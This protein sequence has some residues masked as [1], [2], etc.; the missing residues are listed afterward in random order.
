MWSD[1]VHTVAGM[2]VLPWLG[3][4]ST[5]GHPLDGQSRENRIHLNQLAYGTVNVFSVLRS[6]AD[7][8]RDGQEFALV[9]IHHRNV[10]AWGLAPTLAARRYMNARTG[11]GRR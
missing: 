10:T 3:A 9:L 11:W 7:A 5:A 1:D 4:P 2:S 8:F 6:G